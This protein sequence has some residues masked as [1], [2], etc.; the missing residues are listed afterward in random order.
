MRGVRDIR[1]VYG[2]EVLEDFG[3]HGIGRKF[4]QPPVVS[5][6]EAAAGSDTQLL[7]GYVFTLE[8]IFLAGHKNTTRAA[9][10]WSVT[11]DDGALASHFEHTVGV[12]ESHCRVFTEAKKEKPEDDQLEGF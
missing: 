2:F 3:G 9:D 6:A 1:Q 10:G 4:H 7:P 5:H 12:T 11:T 8:P